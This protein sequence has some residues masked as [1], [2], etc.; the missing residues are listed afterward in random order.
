MSVQGPAP[1]PP[2]GYTAR[3]EWDGANWIGS[4]VDLPGAH[5]HAPTIGELRQRLR[6]VAV[7]MADRPDSDLTDPDAFTIVIN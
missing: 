7:L 6:E 4:I 5:T 2:T 3:V 1:R